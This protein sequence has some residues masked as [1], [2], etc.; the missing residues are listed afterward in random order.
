MTVRRE[1]IS[2]NSPPQHQLPAPPPLRAAPSGKQFHQLILLW[3]YRKVWPFYKQKI[4]FVLVENGLA[5]WNSCNK[6]FLINLT[7]GG[8]SSSPPIFPGLFHQHGGASSFQLQPQQQPF[9]NTFRVNPIYSNN[10]N[11]SSN[12]D[13]LS[14]H[15]LFPSENIY[16]TAAKLLF[17]CVKWS[18]SVP[19]FLQVTIRSKPFYL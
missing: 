12:N 6:Y 18:K 13:F 8:S 17:M 1:D 15:L 16:E 2:S 11:S 7:S 9:L 14:S 4:F 10:N 19:S 5:I 3:L